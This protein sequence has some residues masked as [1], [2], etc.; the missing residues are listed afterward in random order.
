MYLNIWIQIF[1]LIIA[2]LEWENTYRPKNFHK[3]IL[4]F[5]EYFSYVVSTFRYNINCLICLIDNVNIL[6]FTIIIKFKIKVTQFRSNQE[7][8]MPVLSIKVQLKIYP[9][10]K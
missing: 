3:T 2:I 1:I 8:F 7:W 9:E 5:K 6:Y 4:I 10:K